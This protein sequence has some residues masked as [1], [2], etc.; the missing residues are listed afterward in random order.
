MKKILLLLPCLSAIFSCTT[1]ET[2][3]S[4]ELAS[5]KLTV[6]TRLASATI[7]WDPVQ[8]ADGY[9]YRID[10]GQENLVASDVTSITVEDLTKGEHTA[11]VWSTGDEVHTTNS[12]E[13]STTFTID[14]KLQTPQPSYEISEDMQS[15]T[16]TWEA[17]DGA[18]GYVYRIGE[19]EEK[20]VGSDVTS[21]TESNL[22]AG[23]TYTF[24]MHATGEGN[25]EDSDAAMLSFSIV[26]VSQGVWARFT[27]GTT[28]QLTEQSTGIWT[29]TA[30]CAAQSEFTIVKDGTVYG[31]T[32]WSGNG[33]IGTVNS[34]ASAVP[35]Y[36][37][38]SAVYYVRQ[39]LGQMTAGETENDVN[40][41]WVNMDSDC[42]I[43]ITVD[44]TNS[45]GILR[46]RLELKRD[47]DP[48]VV[49]EQYFDLMVF[50]GD[51]IQTGKESKS[52]KKLGSSST[53]NVDGTEPGDTDASYTT[54]GFSIVSDETASPQYLANRGLTGWDLS[55]CFE[56]PGYVRLSNSDGEQPYGIMTTPALE[57]LG[58]GSSITVTFDALRFASTASIPV[59][60]I[61]SG[62]ITSASV[63]VEGNGSPVTVTPEADG[64]SILILSAH[65]PKHANGDLKYWSNFTM[66][67]EGAGPD[68]KISWDTCEADTKFSNTRICLDNIVI[69]KL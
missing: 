47:E 1:E 22:E 63:T 35:F 24:T 29:A 36:T 27:D 68:T 42:N 3:M 32:T 50:G 8:K 15:V 44:A 58:S 51:W 30:D 65:T 17:V 14:P 67:I 26:D 10:D 34:Q 41:F 45:D 12:L 9:A 37:Y 7:S 62:S 40:R 28:L 19:G 5:P 55:Y 46:Y 21:V 49:L 33:G 66:T 13:R 16:F 23:V 54:F 6:T 56:Y 11:Y 69:K 25:I 4:I 53:E 48:S 38:P 57:S 18:S 59:K 20:T 64:K 31:F 2:D 52:G 61:G 39:S 60:V 43:D